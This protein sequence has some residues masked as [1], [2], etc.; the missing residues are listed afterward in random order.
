LAAFRPR[1]HSLHA[2]AQLG[3]PPYPPA[4]NG[5]AVS[6][7]RSAHADR[8]SGWRKAHGCASAR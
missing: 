6:L 7:C 1:R 3:L 4:S 5:I 2:R 8:L